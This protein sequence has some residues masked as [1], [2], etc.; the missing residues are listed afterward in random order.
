MW[1]LSTDSAVTDA[2]LPVIM[3]SKQCS[4]ALRSCGMLH[5]PSEGSI[6]HRFETVQWPHLLGPGVQ[7]AD[8]EEEA[9]TRYRDFVQRT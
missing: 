4:W 8:E 1:P 2:N 5:S 3:H 6:F 7:C 9:I